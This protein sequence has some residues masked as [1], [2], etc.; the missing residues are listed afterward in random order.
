MD[1]EMDSIITNTGVNEKYIMKQEF[2]STQ[3]NQ[4][5]LVYR[6]RCYT[7]KRTNRNDKCWICASG[8]R[9]CPGKLYTNLDAT[10]V[11]RTGEH[12]EGCQVDAHAFYHQQ[13]LNELK[14]LVAGDLRPVLEIYDELAS[15]ASTSLATAAHFPTWEQDRNTMYYSRSKRYP[16]LPARRQD[17]QLIAEQMTTK[18]GAQFL[19]YHS[20]TNNILI[21]ANEA[22]VRLLAQSNCW[23]GDGTRKLLPVVYCLTGRKDLLTYNRIFKYSIPKRK[24]LAS[25][26][27]WPLIT[28]FQGNFPNTRVQGWFFQLLPRCASAGRPAW[29]KK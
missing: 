26:L 25:K 14:R 10:Q 23:C 22:G 15:N 18:S 29:L 9:G 12:A 28:T 11:I 16:R 5:K 17:L 21:F 13:Q 24:N 2:V 19:M 27:I 6:G 3:R 1:A 8:T 4:Q 7:L 20:P